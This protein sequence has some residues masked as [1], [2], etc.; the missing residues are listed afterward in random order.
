MIRP[1]G[2]VGKK[3]TSIERVLG[4]AVDMSEV[5]MSVVARCVDV[6]GLTPINMKVDSLTGEFRESSAAMVA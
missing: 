4:R 2:L 3:V 1:C 5:K 6:F